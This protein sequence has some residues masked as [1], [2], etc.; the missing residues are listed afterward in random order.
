MSKNDLSSGF[1]SNDPK[2]IFQQI[3]SRLK[4]GFYW[5]YRVNGKLQDPVVDLMPKATTCHFTFL[6]FVDPDLPDDAYRLTRDITP[7][8]SSQN[9]FRLP[10]DFQ[11]QVLD[12]IFR[13]FCYCAAECGFLGLRDD[14]QAEPIYSEEEGER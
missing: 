1:S 11:I 13:L 12:N 10:E 9:F 2:T 5:I 3:N 7:K 8:H 4:P 14:E 6:D